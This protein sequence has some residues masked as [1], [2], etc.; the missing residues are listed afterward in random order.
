[1]TI[2]AQVRDKTG[3]REFVDLPGKI[4]RAASPYCPP[5]S[6]HLNLMLGS[7]EQPDKFLWVAYQDG[8]PVARLGAKRHRHGDYDALHFGFYESMEVGPEATVALFR[9]A[10]LRYPELTMRGP[11]QFRMEDPYT[12]LLVD[13]FDHEPHFFMGYNPPYYDSYVRAAAGMTTSMDLYTYEFLP[14]N[15]KLDSLT[16]KHEKGLAKGFTVRNLDKRKLGREAENLASIFNDALSENWGFEVLEKDQIDDLITLS[17]LFLDPQ[18]VFFAEKDGEAVGCVIILPNFNPMIKRSQG[19]IG[20]RFLWD[21][22]LGRKSIDT[23]R[24][25]A[26]GVRKEYR[27]TEVGAMLVHSIMQKFKVTPWKSVE[28]SW[29][30]SNNRPM[31]LMAVGLGGRRTKIYRI[32]EAVPDGAKS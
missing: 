22:L 23:F 14:A 12:G 29:I 8:Q 9:E 24:C 3:W 16:A 27:S 4:Y 32:Y 21:F 15:V 28:M 10:R 5:L 30:L 26:I 19:R 20:P 17:R 18:F 11:Y 2:V 7:L 1:M 25:Y 13:G 6:F 31:N